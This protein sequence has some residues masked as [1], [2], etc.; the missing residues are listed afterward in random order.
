MV[1]SNSNRT[2]KEVE[3]QVFHCKGVISLIFDKVVLEPTFFPMYA[4]LCS[5]LDM[6]FPIAIGPELTVVATDVN[7]PRVLDDPQ[8]RTA[9]LRIS[10]GKYRQ[11]HHGT[12]LDIDSRELG[13]GHGVTQ[14]AVM[15]CI[16]PITL[17]GAAKRSLNNLKIF[18]TSSKMEKR[19][20]TRLG[21]VYDDAP[22][23]DASSNETNKIHEVSFIDVQVAQED[24]DLPSKGLPC[25][26]LPKEVNPGPNLK[27][28]NMLVEIADI[29]KKVPLGVVE[30][31]LVKIDKFLFPLDFLIID[32]LQ[33]RNETMILGRP[34]LA[35]I[36][37]EI[38]IFNKEISLGIGNDR[39]IFDMDTKSYKFTAPIE[40]TYMVN[41]VHSKDVINID[42]N[43]FLYE[44][45]SYEFNRLLAIDPDIFTY[46]IDIQELY[47]EI[48]Y[49]ER[50]GEE[51]D[52][53]DEGWEDPKKCGEEKMNAILDTVLDKLDDSWFSGTIQ[54]D[55]DLDG[56]TNY[57]EPTSYDG[58]IDSED[59]A[60]IEISC[61]LL[62]MPYKKPPPILIERVEVTRYNIGPGETYTKIN[63]LGIDE[64][65]LT[66]ANVVTI[67]AIIMDEIN[68][69][70]GAEG[71]T[72][73]ERSF[74][75]EV[76][77]EVISTHNHV[78]KILLQ[79]AFTTRDGE[80]GGDAVVMFRG[81]GGWRGGVKE[82]IRWCVGCWP[83]LGWPEILSEKMGAP[84]RGGGRKKRIA[85]DVKETLRSDQGLS[86]CLNTSSMEFK[87]STP[88]KHEVKQVQQSC[89]GEDCWELY[90]PDLVP[91]VIYLV[92][93]VIVSTDST[94]C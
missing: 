14:D 61:K 2:H 43:L 55:A 45:K 89:L 20:Y 67:R 50:F 74:S 4:Q 54:D 9:E 32:M 5:D 53:T 6:N 47:D 58:F 41:T 87:E 70:G 29:T 3:N 22:F 73:N 8:A 93:L 56:I 1:H 21:K 80:D 40:K 72:L 92:P 34:F 19:H 16:F 57:L 11:P 91:L 23:N 62:G 36:H 82:G 42:C 68:A 52:D 44:S 33:T 17:T 59:E 78:V 51:D 77:F 26:L 60:Y 88:K 64:I 69:E 24:D 7:V 28:T 84:E 71:E 15:L 85:K 76:K 10:K 39:I 18:A 65:P 90:I 35:T 31:I 25:Q 46:D 75:K 13:T 79:V 38:D 86:E 30:N 66:S 48:T 27:E 12:I 49:R 63:I 83:E 81:M 94:K 37:A